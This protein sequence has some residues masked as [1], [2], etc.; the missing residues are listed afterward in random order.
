MPLADLAASPI[1][2]ILAFVGGAALL[3]RL[4]RSLLRL[5]L[6]AVEG[7]A[8]NGLLEVAIRSGDLTGMAERKALAQKIRRVRMGAVLEALGWGSLVVAPIVAGVVTL[9]YA[10]AAVVWLFPRRPIRP[11]TVSVPS[12][13]SPPAQL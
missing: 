1:A 3:Y 12:N 9:V 10:P 13:P 7:T 2:G 4:G 11:V 5:G 8:V 6:A